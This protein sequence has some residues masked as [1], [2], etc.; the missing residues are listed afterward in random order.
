MCIILFTTIAILVLLLGA[1]VFHNVLVFVGLAL[2]LLPVIVQIALGSLFG[3]ARKAAFRDWQRSFHE[4]QRVQLSGRWY[5]RVANLGL[6]PVQ[7][8][9]GKGRK[10]AVGNAS[11][12]GFTE[13]GGRERWWRR[14]KRRALEL[15]TLD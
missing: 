11:P 13:I 8:W 12:F 3:Y 2:M 9:F 15:A 1:L 4:G 7:E 6:P 14:R 5:T 10:S